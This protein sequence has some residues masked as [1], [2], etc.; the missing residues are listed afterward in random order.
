MSSKVKHY[1]LIDGI[2]AA[3]NTFIALALCS[4]CLHISYDVIRIIAISIII[5]IS[6]AINLFIL[7]FFLLYWWSDIKWTKCKQKT[8]RIFRR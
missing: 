4:L 6:S 7:L 3:I 1:L 5:I 2:G 8:K